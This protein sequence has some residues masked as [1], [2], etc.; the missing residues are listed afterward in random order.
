MEDEGGDDVAEE[1]LRTLAS[2][3]RLRTDLAA[4]MAAENWTHA[5]D[6]VKDL[7][8][9]CPCQEELSLTRAEI[10]AMMGTFEESNRIIN[11]IKGRGGHSKMINVNVKTRAPDPHAKK[12]TKCK[13]LGNTCNSIKNFKSNFG[14]I[15]CLFFTF[16]QYFLFFNYNIQQALHEVIFKTFYKDFLTWIRIGIDKAAG[17]K[18]A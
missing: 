11:D 13:E 10:L 1:D 7:R 3:E 17:S 5:L 12:Q 6:V 16:D 2:I 8:F 14:P 15:P 18:S 4:S 9:L